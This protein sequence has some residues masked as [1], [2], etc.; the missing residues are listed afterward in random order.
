MLSILSPCNFNS[1][2]PNNKSPICSL[3]SPI[4]MSSHPNS[5]SRSGCCKHQK[6]LP[7]YSSIHIDDDFD[8]SK[9]PKCNGKET[10]ARILHDKWFNK[11]I[12]TV[13]NHRSGI[14]Y[15][16]MIEHLPFSW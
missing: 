12:T 5:P 13:T 11:T 4:V 7:F 15:N 10:H 8:E 14:R 2:P 3:P 9:A 6:Y 1:S 16:T